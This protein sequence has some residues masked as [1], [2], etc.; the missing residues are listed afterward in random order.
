MIRGRGNK[1]GTGKNKMAADE[2]AG[3]EKGKL[4][5]PRDPNTSPNN[6]NPNPNRAYHYGKDY[7]IRN[8]LRVP[9]P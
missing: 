1:F 8:T 9:K 7:E 3:T 4:K 6:R 5:T 2:A